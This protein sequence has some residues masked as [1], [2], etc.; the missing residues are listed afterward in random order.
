MVYPMYYMFITSISNGMLV[1]QGRITLLP[2]QI[3]LDTYKVLLRNRDIF[4]SLKNSVVYTTAGTLINLLMSCLCAYPL[5]RKTFS[6]RRLF[7]KMIVVT[8]FF[9][10][11]MIPLYLVVNSLKLIDSIWAIVLPVAINTYNMIIIRTSFQ[12]VPESLVESAKLDG[13]ND[14][15]ILFRI[16]IP[17]SKAVLATMLL[18]YAVSHWNSYFNEMIYLNSKSKYPLQIILRNMLISGLFSEESGQTGSATGFTV[19]D[20]TLRS[21]VIV[22]TTIPILAVYP[23]VQRYFVKGVMIGSLKG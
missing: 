16:V 21:A 11:G 8:M 4:V 10:G 15:S 3:T 12:A 1:M 18:F 17:V 2:R 6:G 19:T 22:F 14:F 13:A 23:F 20:A 5:S 7:T 9:T